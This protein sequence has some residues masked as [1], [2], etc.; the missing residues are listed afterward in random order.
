[1][2]HEERR[3]RARACRAVLEDGLGE[4]LEEMRLRAVEAWERA[5]DVEER[6]ACWQRVR[7]VRDLVMA[8]R[9]RADDLKVLGDG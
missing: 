3:R 9:M 6:E 4:V 5:D 7:A 2:T 1:M 8:L